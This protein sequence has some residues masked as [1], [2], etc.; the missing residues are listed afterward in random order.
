MHPE[1]S[2]ELTDES[3]IPA[4]RV[5][6]ELAWDLVDYLSAQRLCV[7]YRYQA[8]S[9]IAYFHHTDLAAVQNL[10]DRWSVGATAASPPPHK[11]AHLDRWLVGHNA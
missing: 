2:I 4:A 5:P 3:G 1:S 7:T 8:T 6:H 9:V 10:L 11:I